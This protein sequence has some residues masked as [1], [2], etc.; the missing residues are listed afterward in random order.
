VSVEGRQLSLDDIEHGIMRPTFA[1]P[2]VHYAVNCAAIG[3]P[4]LAP[5]AWR[6]ETL[7]R[8]L[9]GAA[10]AFI[11]HPRGVMGRPDGSLRVSSIYK[12]FKEDFGGTDAGIIA[13]LRRYA[14]PV[15]LAK[16]TADARIFDDHYDWALNDVDGGA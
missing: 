3:C 15:L 12:W 1:D 9:D 16:L 11:N 10:R 4:N 7:D 6:A 5:R 8:D 14:G 2:R 13:H